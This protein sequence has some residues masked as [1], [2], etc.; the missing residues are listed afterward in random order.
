ML[1]TAS[2]GH[3]CGQPGKPSPMPAVTGIPGE[4]CSRPSCFRPDSRW[5]L[6]ST[7]PPPWMARAHE[8]E[9][10]PRWSH[11]VPVTKLAFTPK[12]RHAWPAA[13]RPELLQWPVDVVVAA[14]AT[15]SVVLTELPGTASVVHRCCKPRNPSQKPP[16]WRNVGQRLATGL[17]APR[18]A[19][20]SSRSPSRSWPGSWSTTPPGPVPPPSGPRCPENRTPTSNPP[21]RTSAATSHRTT[22][23]LKEGHLPA[24]PRHSTRRCAPWSSFDGDCADFYTTAYET[25]IIVR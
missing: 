3:R 20:W 10:T 17:T 18:A 11:G 13:F 24:S 5:R 6:G 4:P 12:H 2:A 9:S 7:S 8:S 19:R 23:L 21:R 14:T 25:G 1:G 22:V 16:A 15:A